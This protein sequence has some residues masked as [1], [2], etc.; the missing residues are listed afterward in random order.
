MLI[1]LFTCLW[2]LNEDMSSP[3]WVLGGSTV[4]SSASPAEAVGS[5]TGGA[6]QGLRP[7]RTALL[8]VALGALR[9]L[10]ESAGPGTCLRLPGWCHAAIPGL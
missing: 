2:W 3:Q 4:G 1:I 10:G 6:S 9:Q 8:Q 5:G 7:E